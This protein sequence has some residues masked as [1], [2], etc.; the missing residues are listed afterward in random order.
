MDRDEIL[1]LLVSLVLLIGMFTGIYIYKSY[2]C[3]AK[4]SYYGKTSFGLFQGCMITTKEGKYIP[5]ET[6][7]EFDE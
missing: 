3:D 1:L 5:A 2:S 7:R 4:F 6:L